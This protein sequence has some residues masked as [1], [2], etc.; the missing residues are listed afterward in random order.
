M[1]FLFHPL[2]KNQ[3]TESLLLLLF[4]LFQRAFLMSL[5]ALFSWVF[6]SFFSP[7]LCSTVESL[8]LQWLILVLYPS[9]IQEC[10]S[11]VENSNFVLPKSQRDTSITSWRILL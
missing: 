9:A 3:L 4:S 10:C 1:L 11:P 6:W 7:F 2:K 5:P 8:F